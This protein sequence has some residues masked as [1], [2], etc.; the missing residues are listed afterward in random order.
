M[1]ER[2]LCAA[3]LKWAGTVAN[4]LKEW[5]PDAHEN[6]CLHQFLE[7]VLHEGNLDAFGLNFGDFRS[8]PALL[9]TV[10]VSLQSINFHSNRNVFEPI[11][12]HFCLLVVLKELHKSRKKIKNKI[13]VNVISGGGHFCVIWFALQCKI[14]TKRK[15]LWWNCSE[16]SSVLTVALIRQLI[17]LFV[18]FFST[19]GAKLE[20]D[21]QE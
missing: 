18:P 5:D 17:V 12:I 13:D 20:P 9:A 8:R 7:L 19:I 6:R 14:F 2:T 3:S 10:T 1:K 21:K 16:R 4:V 15:P 11:L